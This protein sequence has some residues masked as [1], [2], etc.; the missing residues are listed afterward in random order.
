[1]PT[2]REVTWMAMALDLAITLAGTSGFPTG[3]FAVG[4]K[5]HG[6]PCTYDSTMGERQY[7][8]SGAWCN[9]ATTTMCLPATTRQCE[10]LD[11]LAQHH[12][13]RTAPRKRQRDG[14]CSIRCDV[15]IRAPLQ[16]VDERPHNSS[17]R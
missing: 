7:A 3:N 8:R 14:A 5:K 12:R 16:I 1:M 9:T 17:M 13:A 15:A 11:K 4:A 2:K 6:Q 10:Q